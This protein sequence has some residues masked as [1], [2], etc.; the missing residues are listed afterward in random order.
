MPGSPDPTHHARDE[1]GFHLPTPLWLSN[2]RIAWW[3]LLIGITCSQVAL[4][5][6]GGWTMRHSLSLPIFVI[7]VLVVHPL[8]N[9]KLPLWSADLLKSWRF[10]AFIA[11]V[12]IINLIELKH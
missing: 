3:A 12:A 11:F 2:R 5:L 9:Q 6:G 1:G 4:A 7:A 8:M 10:Y